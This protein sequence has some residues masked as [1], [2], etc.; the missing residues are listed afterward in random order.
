MAN[1]LQRVIPPPLLSPDGWAFIASLPEQIRQ[2]QITP[3]ASP[4]QVRAA[5]E[6]AVSAND[7]YKGGQGTHLLVETFLTRINRHC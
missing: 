3:P 7:A 6:I 4:E 2:L 5:H 1:V